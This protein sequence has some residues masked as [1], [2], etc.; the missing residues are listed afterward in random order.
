MIEIEERRKQIYDE[1]EEKIK[2]TSID[3]WCCACVCEQCERK[4]D[5]ARVWANKNWVKTQTRLIKKP[6]SRSLSLVSVLWVHVQHANVEET[7]KNP[8]KAVCD[9]LMCCRANKRTRFIRSSQ[10]KW[11]DSKNLINFFRKILQRL[12]QRQIRSGEGRVERELSH[13]AWK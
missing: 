12:A 7:T 4:R 5:R 8:N 9:Q 11:Y 13:G 6:K 10:P 2:C 3:V 1:N